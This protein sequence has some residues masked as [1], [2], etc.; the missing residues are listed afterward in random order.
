MTTEARK[1]EVGKPAV[2]STE[3]RWRKYDLPSV[4]MLLIIM[5]ALTL[6]FLVGLRFILDDEYEFE[7]T[8][9]VAIL[10]LPVGVIGAVA[11]G[12]FGYSLGSRGAAEAQANEAVA[13]QEKIT[14]QR[15]AEAS[16]RDLARIIRKAKEGGESAQKPEKYEIS[17]DDLNTLRG[18][19]AP[20]AGKLGID[21]PEDIPP[22]SRQRDAQEQGQA[23][24]NVAEP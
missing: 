9:I 8:D 4:L 7:A 6:I 5:A 11:A 12:I 15:D 1:P 22:P 18:S 23:K 17:R 24:P 3:D 2:Q 21:L 16:V 19:A 20:M 13:T 10:S 14:V